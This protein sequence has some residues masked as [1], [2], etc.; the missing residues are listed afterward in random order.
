MFILYDNSSFTEPHLLGLTKIPL[1]LAGR[2][3][4]AKSWL[5]NTKV[6]GKH[7]PEEQNGVQ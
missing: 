7:Q 2:Q 3:L 1:S 6:Q 4:W 5:S